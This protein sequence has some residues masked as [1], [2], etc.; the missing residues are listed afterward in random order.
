MRQMYYFVCPM[1]ISMEICNC[2][3][4]HKSIIDEIQQLYSFMNSAFLHFTRPLKKTK[5]KQ[6]QLK[7]AEYTSRRQCVCL[8]DVMRIYYKFIKWY[9]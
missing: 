4:L 8:N 1:G 2:F 9:Y 3:G 6:E 5:T 7:N